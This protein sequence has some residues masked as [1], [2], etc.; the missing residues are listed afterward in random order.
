MLQDD[1]T[2][3]AYQDFRYGPLIFL[4]ADRIEPGSCHGEREVMSDIVWT[5]HNPGEILP[6]P[7]LALGKDKAQVL[8]DCLWNCGIRPSE[9][10]A[11]PAISIEATQKHLADMRALVSHAWKI[12]LP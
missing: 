3:F 11:L 6:P 8:M 9:N 2:I 4:N 5:K 12:T 1:I 7:P 10:T